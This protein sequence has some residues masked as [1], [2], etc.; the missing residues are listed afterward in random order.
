[1]ESRLK[2]DEKNLNKNSVAEKGIQEL[3][4]ELVKLAPE[5]Q[6]VNKLLLAKAT[7]N[8][9]SRIRHTCRS[10]QELLMKRSVF[11]KKS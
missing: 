2:L 7:H 5:G 11:M 9:N 10:A 1:M 3:E 4:E 8:L 6:P